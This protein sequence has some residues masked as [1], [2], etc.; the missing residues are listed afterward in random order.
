[1]N[2]RTISEETATIFGLIIAIILILLKSIATEYDTYFDLIRDFIIF[3]LIFFISSWLIRNEYNKKS[4][5]S[6]S[7]TS[8]NILKKIRKNTTHS[9]PYFVYL[10]PFKTTGKLKQKG[11]EHN[12]KY[13]DS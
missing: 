9:N 12:P 13:S 10:R 7:I 8:R 11:K 2:K 3:I 4:Q 5:K 1:M 6:R